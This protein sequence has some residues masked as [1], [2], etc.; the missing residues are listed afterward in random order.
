LKVLITGVKGFLGKALWEFLRTKHKKYEVYGIVRRGKGTKNIFTCDL[1]Q[2]RKLTSYLRKLKP[3]FIFHLAGGRSEDKDILYRANVLTTKSLFHAIEFIENYRPRVIIPGTAAEYGKVSAHIKHIREMVNSKPVSMY[4]ICKHEQTKVAYR[5]FQKDYDVIITR[6]FNVL[7][8]ATP[9]SLVIGKFA[10]DISTFKKK[11]KKDTL[12]MK[13]CD[14]KR[15]F[16]DISDV[17]SALVALAENGKSGQVYNICSGNSY[18]IRELLNDLITIANI[19]NFIL[20]KDK[21]I[22][23]KS[24][25]SIG[26][27]AKLIRATGWKPKVRI[28]D[29]LKNTL[30]FYQ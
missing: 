27:N 14:G 26:S 24:F 22:K 7:G 16:L 28:K 21:K 10:K 23:V 6:I 30:R 15:D 19:K 18:I 8:Y 12:L 20:C 13:Y 5:Y 17:C 2:E 11:R 25:N 9:E 29:G 1:L 4:G 3:D